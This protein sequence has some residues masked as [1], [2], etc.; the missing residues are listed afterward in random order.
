MAMSATRCSCGFERLDDEE[1]I[2]HL[3]ALFGPADHQGGDGQQHEEWQDRSCSCGF[4]AV[5]ADELDEH[6][7]KLCTPADAVAHDGR[8]HEPVG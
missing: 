5:L 3:L 6:F 7:L 8:K 1:V 4:T 2:D